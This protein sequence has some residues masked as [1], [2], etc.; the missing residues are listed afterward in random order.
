MVK[1]GRV[2]AAIGAAVLLGTATLAHA[3]NNT[4][5]TVPPKLSD[6]SQVGGTSGDAQGPWTVPTPHKTYAF[7]A[8]GRWGVKLDMAEPTNRDPDWKDAQ[9][10]AYF[11]VSPKFRVSGAV[12]LGD[13]FSQPQHITPEDTGPRVHLEGAF[14][15]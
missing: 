7:D 5:A 11:R 15:F 13:K 4:Q 2:S 12:G 14:K 1:L 8:K 6:F 9:V 3:E 10:G